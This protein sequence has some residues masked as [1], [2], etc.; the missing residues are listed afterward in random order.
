MTANQ[1]V[2]V[3]PAPL[4]PSQGDI[5]AGV[6]TSV[7][8]YMKELIPFVQERLLAFLKRRD[9]A[10]ATTLA[11]AQ[12]FAI[13]SDAKKT[14]KNFREPWD[15][16]HCLVSLTSTQLYEASG[17][18]FWLGM[19]WTKFGEHSLTDAKVTWRQL[20]DAMVLWGQ[21]AFIASCDDPRYRRFIFPGYI[22]TAVANL[23][24]IEGMIK[25][26]ANHFSRLCVLAGHSLVYA[27]CH[28]LADALSATGNDGD[29]LKVVQC[30]RQAWPL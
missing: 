11:E 3:N 6:A 13:S 19:L 26:E 4:K 22:P 29:V 15:M 2:Q 5:D 23:S 25:A 10:F 12:P 17:N 1:P 18:S 20:Q 30:T 8:D 27:W 9:P 7:K 14:F 21:D 16:R 24:H 28:A